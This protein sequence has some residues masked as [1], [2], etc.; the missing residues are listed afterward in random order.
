MLI[1]NKKFSIYPLSFLNFCS[2]AVVSISSPPLFPAPPTPTSH[3]HPSPLWLCLW[4]L[5]T[6]SLMT[7]SLLSPIIPFSLPSGY[8][9]FVLHFNV[10][11]YILLPCF[12]GQVPL[13]GQIIWYLIKSFLKIEQKMHIIQG[14]IWYYSKKRTC[15]T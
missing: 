10:S 14:K 5:Y 11:G 9:Q 3:L 1:C 6:C 15:Y 7:L 8:C 12:V 13:I 2:N 4:V